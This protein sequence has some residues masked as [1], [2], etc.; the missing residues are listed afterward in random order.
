MYKAL[1]IEFVISREML[2]VMNSDN[3]V[4]QSRVNLKLSL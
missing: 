4:K 2:I 1:W 3:K